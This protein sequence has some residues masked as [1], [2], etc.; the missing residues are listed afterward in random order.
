MEKGVP[1][2]KALAEAKK[3]EKVQEILTNLQKTN[4]LVEFSELKRQMGILKIPLVLDWVQK[5]VNQNP[6]EGLLIFADQHQVI[7]S[8]ANGISQMTNKNGRKIRVAKYTGKTTNK[9]R[10]RIQKQFQAGKIDVMILNKAGNTGLNLQ[11]ASYVLFAERYWNPSDEEQAEDRAHRNGK[12]NPV[13]V[14]YMNIKG[15]KRKDGSDVITID[16]QIA[17]I[18]KTKR[19]KIEEHIGNQKYKTKNVKSKAFTQAMFGALNSKFTKFNKR[20]QNKVLQ[21]TLQREGLIR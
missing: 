1:F 4:G 14:Y 9:E 5:F 15:W 11:R 16:E 17:D 19:K 21:Q 7:D 13:T 10:Q 6:N 12:K 3:N 2:K 18:V 8:L 20:D